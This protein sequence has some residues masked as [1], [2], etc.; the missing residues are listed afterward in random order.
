MRTYCID[1]SDKKLEGKENKNGSW[2]GN[3]G[4]DHENER[5]TQT[6]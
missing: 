1:E 6:E 3:P 5:L 2:A 4:S